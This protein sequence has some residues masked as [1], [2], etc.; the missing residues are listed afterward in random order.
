[1]TPPSR[2][3]RPAADTTATAQLNR[4]EIN[5]GCYLSQTNRRRHTPDLDVSGWRHPANSIV[6]G[7]LGEVQRAG[8]NYVTSA[9]AYTRA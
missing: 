6:V 7:P 2:S 1:M 8:P 5:G 9:D 3:S 4:L